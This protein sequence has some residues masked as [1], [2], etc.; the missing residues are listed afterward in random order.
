MQRD[1]SHIRT[2]QISQV[3]EQP[4]FGQHSRI[5]NGESREWETMR[6]TPQYT[7]NLDVRCTYTIISDRK[8]TGVGKLHELDVISSRLL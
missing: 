7:I 4:N 1:H 3:F 5:D 2:G 8:D 6:K